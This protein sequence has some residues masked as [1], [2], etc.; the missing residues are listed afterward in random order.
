[1][2]NIGD[3]AEERNLL[4]LSQIAHV[5]IEKEELK[6]AEA[7][8]S[9]DEETK[10]HFKSHCKGIVIKDE[11]KKATDA[12]WK[13]LCIKNFDYIKQR[14]TSN[15]YL[16]CTAAKLASQHDFDAINYVTISKKTITD[17]EDKLRHE[18]RSRN[19]A[20]TEYNAKSTTL[21]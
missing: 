12:E 10:A 5:K 9:G 4:L 14:L 7:S 3:Q 17:R 16:K 18:Q 20:T 13:K 19:I 2:P 6:D 1:M 11:F 21:A 8:A 15:K